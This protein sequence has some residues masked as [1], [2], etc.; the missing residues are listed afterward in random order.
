VT[1]LTSSQSDDQRV[2]VDDVSEV[3]RWADFLCASPEQLRK[4][5]EVVGPQISNVKRYLFV[6]LLR[7]HAMG[8][9]S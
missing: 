7:E 3:A 9:R 6:A 1:A 4:A 2:N 5:I 8:Q